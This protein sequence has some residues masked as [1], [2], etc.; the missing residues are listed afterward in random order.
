MRKL[1]AAI[2]VAAATLVAGQAIA[3]DMPYYPPV[4]EI[5]D[6]DY[7]VEGS[8][9]LRGS[10]AGNALWSRE[11]QYFCPSGPDCG[12]GTI[13]KEASTHLG[14]GY[15]A[16]LGFGY[17]T[18]T[19]LRAD[20]TVDYLSNEGAA[21]RGRVVNGNQLN[22]RSTIALANVYYDFGLANYGSSIGGG[23]GAYVGAGLGGAY[24]WIESRGPFT[25]YDPDG[26][27]WSP[28]GA[29]MTGVT[30]DMGSI[31]ADLGYRMIY[32]PQ[33]TNG[34]FA[35]GTPQGPY[36]LNDNLIHEVRGTVRYR[37]N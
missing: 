25:G 18:G 3:A 11:N 32:M 30:Y 13:F 23:F 4:I 24:N 1:I 37:F 34:T 36:Y 20:L 21:Y 31:V 2:T 6:V 28:A 26:G 22:L 16:G 10:V 27:S 7:G 17:E 8:F 33:F 29:L 14:Y 35:Q 5:P 12:T 9:Y 19:G 15:S